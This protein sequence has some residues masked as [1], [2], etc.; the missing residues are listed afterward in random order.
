MKKIEKLSERKRFNKWIYSC[1]YKLH[2][3]RFS[4]S[5]PTHVYYELC[6]FL[7][8]CRYKAELHG[9]SE[10][11]IRMK[12]S[13]HNELYDEILQKIDARENTSS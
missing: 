1:V 10:E 5:V 7:P 11:C 4:F 13:R 8:I 12:P 6:F 2:C 3:L 9:K